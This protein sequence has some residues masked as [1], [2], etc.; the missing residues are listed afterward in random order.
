MEEFDP[1]N[2]VY[3]PLLALCYK[4]RPVKVSSS[5]EGVS[6][7]DDDN[8]C[9]EEEAWDMNSLTPKMVMQFRS[10]ELLREL[11]GALHSRYEWSCEQR[12]T[13]LQNAIQRFENKWI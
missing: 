13:H 10:K 5:M 12:L 8:L 2:L 7:D 11:W 6:K 1:T 3:L 4:E 9:P